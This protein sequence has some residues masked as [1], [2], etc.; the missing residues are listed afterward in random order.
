MDGD[1]AVDSQLDGF[2]RVLPLP[3]RVALIIVMGIWA[4][5]L[6]LHYLSLI[7]IDVP[8]LIRYPGRSSP[9]HPSHHLSTYRIASFLSIPLVLSLLLFWT[10]TSGSPKDIAAWEILPNIYLLVLVVGFIAPMPFVSR[11]GRSRTI[12]TLK[13]ISIGG[14]AEAQDGKFGDILLA[15]ALTSYAKVLGDL[16]ISLCM[17]FSS[18]HSSTG[19]PNRNCGGGFWVPFIISIPSIIRLRQCLIE[20][21][22]IQNANKRTGQIS[23]ST[24]WGGVHLANALKYSSAFPVII[25]SAMQRSPQPSKFGMSEATLFR[26]WLA[27]VFA[28][29]AYSFY[30]DVARDWDLTLFS[31]KKERENPEYPYG[32]RRNRYF[33]AKEFYYAAIAVDA[34]L[35]CTWSFKLS[36]HLDHFNDLEGGIFLMEVLEVFRRW[37]WIFFRVETEWVRNHRGPAP[38]DILLGDMS[39]KFDEDD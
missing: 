36:P 16:F 35:R 27:A 19:P 2:S 1:P 25:L 14:L 17:F 31:S 22:R 4:W 8:S 5:G 15:D 12:A 23:P 30:W 34:M 37:I 26:L 10:L 32:L 7:K 39:N 9:Q 33:N 28:N 29:S 13:R 6:N 3:Y 18:K 24:G 11:N 21:F 38:D 20:Y